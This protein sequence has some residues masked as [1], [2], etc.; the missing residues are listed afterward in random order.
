MTT[1]LT[2]DAVRAELERLG[3]EFPD[4]LNDPKAVAERFDSI[5]CRYTYHDGS[6]CI[7]GEAL[8]NLTGRVPGYRSTY[9][10]MPIDSTYMTKW[11]ERAGVEVNPMAMS[12]LSRA[13]ELADL[14]RPWGEVVEALLDGYGSE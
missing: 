12:L 8:L 7:A 2:Y 6:H 11:M 3:R 14:N 1:T 10:T 13:Q 5:K 4:R 9:N